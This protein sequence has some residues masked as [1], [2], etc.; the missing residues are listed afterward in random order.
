LLRGFEPYL[1]RKFTVMSR[2]PV[3]AGGSQI[4]IL[5]QGQADAL[6]RAW[7]YEGRGGTGGC[8]LRGF[9]KEDIS[10]DKL[11]WI[12]ARYSRLLEDPE[13]AM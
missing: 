10:K 1:G 9:Q 3:A 8:E 4:T 13:H 11:A 7:V 5:F 6:F 12:V 2:D